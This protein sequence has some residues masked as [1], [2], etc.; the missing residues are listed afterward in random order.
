MS[1]N[2]VKRPGAH[3][4]KR[5]KPGPEAIWVAMGMGA[6]ALLLSVSGAFNTSD[7][8]PLHRSTMW[9]IVIG[10][11]AG[12]FVLFAQIFDRL[13]RF[14]RLAP[15]GVWGPAFV[16]TWL[17]GTIQIEALKYTPLLNKQ[18]DPLGA[19]AL[20][21]LPFIAL[22]CLVV[23]AIVRAAGV[24]APLDPAANEAEIAE[25]AAAPWAGLAGLI[26]VEVQDHYLHLVTETD[27]HLV[28]GTMGEALS[29]LSGLKGRQ[30]HRSWWVAAH[31]VVR[32]ERRGR[33]YALVLRDG[34][35]VPVGRGRV[36]A[37]R[38]AGWL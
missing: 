7:L 1:A 36:G 23:F 29:R 34:R 5:L 20:F 3:I 37:L 31:S 28:R 15:W 21:V 11:I 33:D 13:P 2:V 22:V 18:P 12:Q 30:V 4:V 17:S 24:V 8:A 32:S 16:V 35:T 19:F 10:L 26:S 38:K 6:L 14:S 27:Q 9:L 25:E